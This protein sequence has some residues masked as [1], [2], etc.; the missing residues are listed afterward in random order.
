MWMRYA[1]GSIIATI[2]SQIALMTSYGLL[3]ASAAVASIV[4]FFAGTIPNYLLN[5]AWAWGEHQL[6]HRRLMV[7]YVL[8]VVV[9][10][11]IA[12]AMT[13]A[14]DAVVRAHV[15][16]NGP[17]TVL[18]DLAYVTSY[19]LMFIAKYLVFDSVLFKSRTVRSAA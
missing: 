1:A 16:A 10:N 11:V 5:K 14:A 12:I 4:A 7:S 19:G 15:K 8:V 2:L 6:S 3:G 17:R 18:L 13:L 9:T